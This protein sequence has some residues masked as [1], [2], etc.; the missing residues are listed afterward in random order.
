MDTQRSR[1]MSRVFV[2]TWNFEKGVGFYYVNCNACFHILSAIAN[3]SSVDK[4]IA[5]HSIPVFQSMEETPAQQENG[6][7]NFHNLKREY[8][9]GSEEEASALSNTTTETPSIAQDIQPGKGQLVPF[10]FNSNE[11][12]YV[13]TLWQNI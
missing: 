10:L 1:Y 11:R 9:Y 13:P 4:T 6:D 5:L 12:I 2:L 3:V 7:A 8:D